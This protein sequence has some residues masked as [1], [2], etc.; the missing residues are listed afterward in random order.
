M[1]RLKKG[2][3][4]VDAPL[5]DTWLTVKS[6]AHFQGSDIIFDKSMKAEVLICGQLWN[7]NENDLHVWSVFLSNV[8]VHVQLPISCTMSPFYKKKGNR[9]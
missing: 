5:G 3:K 9:K 1:W 4:P 6:Q 8:K 2:I 7:A